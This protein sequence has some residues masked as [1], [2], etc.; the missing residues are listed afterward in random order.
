MV[1]Y[2]LQ[3]RQPPVIPVL[4]EVNT[5]EHLR[6]VLRKGSV[7]LCNVLLLVLQ[8]FDGDS[9]PERMVDGWNAYFFDDLDEMVSIVSE[10]I[11]LRV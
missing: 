11:D 1:L 9:A 8:I 6:N 7:Q 5:P 3:Q 2:Y 4:Q 10:C